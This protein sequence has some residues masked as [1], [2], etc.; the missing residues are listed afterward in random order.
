MSPLRLGSEQDIFCGCVSG[1]T[2]QIKLALKRVRKSERKR[3]REKEEEKSKTFADCINYQVV[4]FHS[5]NINKKKNQ[6][7]KENCQCSSWTSGHRK[8][9]AACLQKQQIVHKCASVDNNLADTIW[10]RC[11]SPALR[12]LDCKS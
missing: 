10:H 11:H 4:R 3:R 8:A 2:G 9:A 6:P 7:K 1:I 12:R 5:L